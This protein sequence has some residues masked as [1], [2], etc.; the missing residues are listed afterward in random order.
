MQSNQK[1]FYHHSEIVKKCPLIYLHPHVI[2]STYVDQSIM[3]MRIE[4]TRGKRGEAAKSLINS[5]KRR[6]S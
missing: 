4:E 1:V 6:P 5:L 2:G 3:S